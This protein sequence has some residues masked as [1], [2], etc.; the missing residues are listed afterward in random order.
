MPNFPGP[1]EVE[2]QYQTNVREHS[3]ALNC[4]A[5]GDPAPGTAIGSISLATKS[6]GTVLLQ[7]AVQNFWN[8]Y[9]IRLPTAGTLIQWVLW[10]YTPETYEKTFITAGTVT[11]PLGASGTTIPLAQTI[12][13]L[14]SGNGGI[15]YINWLEGNV[16]GDTTVALIPSGAGAAEQQVAA[17]LLSSEGWAIA[18]DDGFPIAGYKISRGQ[19]EALWR[20][21]NRPSS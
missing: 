19:N 20:K 9:R 5:I 17:Y 21:S 14:R 6:G 7:T 1:F 8:F 16:G 10:K 15:M 12:A 3:L 4:I 13:S 18:R 2:Y 11:N